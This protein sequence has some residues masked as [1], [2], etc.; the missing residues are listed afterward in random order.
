M[1]Q[2]LVKKKGCD[3]VVESYIQRAHQSIEDLLSYAKE[4]G[5]NQMVAKIWSRVQNLGGSQRKCGIAHNERI[6]MVDSKGSP[7]YQG[8]ARL[9]RRARPLHQ[10]HA[11]LC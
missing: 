1:W 2:S 6:V 5:H 7:K 4:L 8:Y 11:R 3:N 9:H 10:R